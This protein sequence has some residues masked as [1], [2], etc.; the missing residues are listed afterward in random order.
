MKL[1]LNCPG[2]H[3]ITYTNSTLDWLK[4]KLKFITK[5]K[6]NK[7]SA[8]FQGPLY[9]FIYEKWDC[10][11]EFLTRKFISCPFFMIP[12]QQTMYK[13][14]F[15][16]AGRIYHRK[17]RLN[18]NTEPCNW[19]SFPKYCYNSEIHFVLV[20]AF[21]FRQSFWIQNVFSHRKIVYHELPKNKF[22]TSTLS[23]SDVAPKMRHWVW[24]MSGVAFGCKGRSR[25]LKWGVNFCNNVRNQIL[26]QYLRDKNKKERGLR[27]RGWNFTHFTSPG[28]APGTGSEFSWRLF[29]PLPPQLNF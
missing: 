9:V 19:I 6:N 20:T 15:P 3:A 26:F 25:I 11:S 10:M 5:N 18:T 16:I 27:K 22:N 21:L 29:D 23:E 13:I 17:T 2:P 8:T 1:I 7:N 14:Q 12:V 28:S 24:H 4:I